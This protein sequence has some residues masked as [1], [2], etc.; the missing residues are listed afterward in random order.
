MIQDSIVKSAE[1]SALSGVTLTRRQQWA[2]T[3]KKLMQLLGGLIM[4]K[5]EE[6]IYVVSIGRVSWWMVFIPAIGI[7]LAGGGNMNTVG[8]AIKDI[9]PNHFNMLITLAAYNMGKK[10]TDIAS[11]FVS[12]KSSAKQS[13]AAP[14]NAETDGPG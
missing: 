3:K 8:D 11:K 10:I 5:N 12:S 9:S 7:W 4:E 2:L 1:L 14:A 6:G 13:G